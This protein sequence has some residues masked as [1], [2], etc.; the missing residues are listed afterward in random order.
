M[1]LPHGVKRQH[2]L[3]ALR[4]IDQNPLKVP[5]RRGIRKYVLKYKTRYYPPKF[6]ILKASEFLTSAESDVARKIQAISSRIALKQQSTS[7]DGFSGGT[8]TNNFLIRRGFEI[9]DISGPR[10]KRVALQAVEEDPEELFREG[11]VLVQYRKHKRIERNPRLARAAKNRRLA[12]DRYLRCEGCGF[13]FLQKYGDIGAGFIE[14]HHTVPL[15][16]LKGERVASISDIALLCANCHR[17]VHQSDPLLP[18]LKLVALLKSIR[19]K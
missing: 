7:R 16:S 2:I 10:K 15:K 13:S 18:I 4:W 5:K 1:S 6:V 11:K 17:M 3:R 14:A 12:R 19:R 8:E 9:W